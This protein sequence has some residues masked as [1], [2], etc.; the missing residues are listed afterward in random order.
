MNAE[1]MELAM[2]DGCDTAKDLATWYQGYL[3]GELAMIKSMRDDL[4][5]VGVFEMEEEE[6][7]R[8]QDRKEAEEEMADYSDQEYDRASSNAGEL[9]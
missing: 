7:T 8:I 3:R 1:L 2:E 4:N 5:E 9:I 6:R